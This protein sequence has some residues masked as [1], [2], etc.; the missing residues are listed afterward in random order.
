MQGYRNETH[1][2][3]E[4]RNSQLRER[5]RDP[6]MNS[7]GRAPADVGGEPTSLYRKSQKSFHFD[8]GHRGDGTHGSLPMP[9]SMLYTRGELRCKYKP[10]HAVLWARRDDRFAFYNPPVYYLTMSRF[11]QISQ[12]ESRNDTLSFSARLHAR[13]SASR[14]HSS[15]P[16]R[17]KR[18]GEGARQTHGGARAHASTPHA[19][20]LIDRSRVHPASPAPVCSTWVSDEEGRQIG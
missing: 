20:R 13:L 9:F 2:G 10:C 7:G 14:P 18:Y 16:S 15:P 6:C 5:R 8:R 12:I 17:G 19:L 11:I 3:G 1:A 4:L